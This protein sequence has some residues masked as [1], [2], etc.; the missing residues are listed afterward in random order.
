MTPASQAVGRPAP[1]A[2]RA[3]DLFAFPSDTHGWF[4]MLVVVACLV[5][6]NVGFLTARRMYGSQEGDERERIVIQVSEMMGG[7]DLRDFSPQE[8]AALGRKLVPVTREL[9]LSRLPRLAT[10]AL[11]MLLLLAGAAAIYLDHP[12][13]YRRPHRSRPLTKSEA[14]TVVR[15]LTRWSANLGLPAVRLE[16]RPGLGTEAQTFGL[17]GREVLMFHGDPILLERVW[18]ETSKVIALHELGHVKNGDA[19]ERE[20]SKA[21]WLALLGLLFLMGCIFLGV[22][23][24][25]VARAWRT[26]GAD[27]SLAALLGDGWR[28]A[29]LLLFA[30]AIWTGLIHSFEHY[31]DRRVASWGLGSALQRL[32]RLSR[33]R[34]LWHPSNRKR[35]EILSDPSRLF[36][37][38][39]ALAL[40]TGALLSILTVNLIFPVLETAFDASLATS[41]GLWKNL[42]P[43][44]VSLPAPWGTRLLLGT[45]MTLNLGQIFLVFLGPLAVFSYLAAGTLG[46][47]VQREAVADLATGNPRLWGYARLL[48]PA[49][50]LAVGVEAGFRIAPFNSSVETSFDVGLLALWL[51]GLTGFTWLWMAYVRAFTRFTWGLHVGTTLPRRLRLL[52]TGSSSALLTVLYWPAGFV[53][54]APRLS[55]WLRLASRAPGADPREVFV[56]SVVM[57][58]VILAN[59]ALVIY[60]AG[61]GTTL[62]AVFIRLWRRRPHCPACGEPVGL[63]F[64]VGRLC[65]DCEE[66]LAAW[67]YE[68]GARALD[69]QLEGEPCG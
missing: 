3:L 4:R 33:A 8:M 54:L 35:E 40:V 59:L 62:A 27:G 20:M 32:L 7:R 11:L 31:A 69:R 49:A 16:H 61:A 28:L 57:T 19:Q 10:A 22:S 36:R 6:L 46:V 38:S 48:R 56:Y 5:G 29:A 58:G 14:P 50:L 37:V 17:R 47:Q 51:I 23:S 67:A 65:P 55:I 44:F 41:T 66:P 63:G 42:A 24:F 18:G 30:A 9:L 21:L 68:T 64:A 34:R 52:V 60:L 45:V 25:Q 39:P 15:D 2:Q 53:R 13:R 43:L 1:G 12:R 26:G